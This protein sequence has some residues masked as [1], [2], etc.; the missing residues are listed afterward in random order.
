MAA[1][2]CVSQ[3]LL[4]QGAQACLAAP[5]AQRLGYM[6][7]DLGANLLGDHDCRWMC[8]SEALSQGAQACPAAPDA[9]PLQQMVA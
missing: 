7:A 4:L 1:I 5:D 8:R 3:R 9:Q 6:I 2:E